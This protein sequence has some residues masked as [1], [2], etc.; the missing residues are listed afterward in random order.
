MNN[1]SFWAKFGMIAGI[2]A[3]IAILL[4]I[5]KY[6]H[7]M[8]T[9]Q[10]ALQQ[11]VTEMKQ[12]NDGIIRNQSQYVSKDDLDKFAK[13]SNIDLGPIRD[14]L[15]KLS[16]DVK[17][18]SLLQVVTPGYNG[19]NIHSSNTLPRVGGPFPTVE[20]PCVGGKAICPTIDT[21]GYLNS[22]QVL[23]LKEPFSDGTSIPF[24]E[25]R[26]KAWQANPWD[27]QIYPRTYSVTTVLGQDDDGKH[28]VYNKFTIASNGTT[29]PVVIK[30]AK[31]V[32]EFPESKLHFS[33]RLNM[34]VGIGALINPPS[35]EVTP[36][37]YVSLLNYGKTNTT[38]DW[39]FL[40]VGLGYESQI[41]RLGIVVSPVNYNVGKHIPLMTNIYIGP[42]IS[43]DTA[44]SFGL[45]GAL[46]VGL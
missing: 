23:T 2:L 40:G 37:L 46:S 28:Y 13:N 39:T 26:F 33:P 10:A 27:L 42:M 30:D 43:I 25:T 16:A 12:L 35:V 7:D 14:D 44:G 1:T 18:I 15:K 22:A 29:Y 36:N 32:E 9:K 34:S 17:G 20:I 3:L 4:F 6:Q 19:Q 21:F 31:F 24:G 8:L 5:V 41:K 38:P 45:L 11:S